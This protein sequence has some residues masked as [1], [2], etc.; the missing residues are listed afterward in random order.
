M[1]KFLKQLCCVGWLVLG[2]VQAQTQAPAPAPPETTGQFFATVWRLRGDVFA[3]LQA[4]LPRKLREGDTVVVG[5]QVRAGANGEAVL[6]TGDAGLVAVRS[7]AEFAAERFAAEGKASDHQTLRLVVGSLRVISGWIGQINRKDNTIVTSTST[8]GI[9]GTDHEPY[10]LAGEMVSA[11]NPAGTYDKVNRGSTVLQAQTG[12]VEIEPGGVGFARDPNAPGVRKRALMTLLFPVLLDK[13]PAFYVPGAFESEINLYSE[14]ADALSRKQLENLTGVAP[15]ETSCVASALGQAWLAR[16]DTALAQRD[17]AGILALFAPNIV[18]QATVR[19]GERMVTLE[20]ERE[21]MARST[22][23]SIASLQDYQQRRVS[24]Q[25]TL[26]EGQTQASCQRINLNSVVIEQGL[27]N[28]K[29]YRFE[30]L[31]E[32]VLA[33]HDGQWLATSA[34]T[35]QR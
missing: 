16:L 8:I 28:G 5:E 32:Y 2:T 22:L 11:I 1:K 23:R 26:A 18:A 27:M 7:G 30:S 29:P 13:V 3:S 4:H 31:E 17:A 6:K 12:S 9:R 15:A 35:T 14:Q 33:I 19:Q 20:F 25:A 34:H 21:E 24:V 10:V